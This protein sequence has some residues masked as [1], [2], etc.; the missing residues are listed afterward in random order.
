MSYLNNKWMYLFNTKWNW[1]VT[2]VIDCVKVIGFVQS[3]DSQKV[4]GLNLWILV[5]PMWVLCGF[6]SVISSQ[7]IDMQIISIGHFR[8][9]IAVNVCVHGSLSLCI[10]L[11]ISDLL[12]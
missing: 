5:L 12:I 10:E 1:V 3:P 11:S 4:L 6:P 8:L 2:V 9:P 7:S